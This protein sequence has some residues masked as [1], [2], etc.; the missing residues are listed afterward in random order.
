MS[1][2]RIGSNISSLQAQRKLG[3]TSAALSR[4][5]ERLAS[6]QRINRA[7]DDAAGLAI[8]E[9]LKKDVR[10][11]SQAVRNVNDGLSAL[12]IAEGALDQ[13]SAITMRQQELAAQAANGTYSLSQRRAMNTEANA[14]VEE[15]NRIVEST[16]FNG[17]QLID[18]SLSEVRIQ[19]G[20][21]AD[22]SISFGLGDELERTVG[23]GQYT[24]QGSYSAGTSSA[25]EVKAA[26][27]NGDGKPDLISNNQ[28]PAVV[29]VWNGN[30][31]GTFASGRT[32]ST[33]AQKAGLWFGWAKWQNSCTTTYS[34][35][36]GGIT[37][38]R[39]ANASVPVRR[40]QEPQRVC[41]SRTA[42]LGICP[43]GH[44]AA[45]CG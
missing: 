20:Y 2:I 15:F 44:T 29:V 18:N 8:A 22:G 32:F 11:Y 33:A 34:C 31:D 26:D 24:G 45:N 30:G 7:S 6:G 3:Q 28:S 39:C 23:T 21:G 1:A 40:L 9:S 41:M 12:Y 10:V 5:F 43:P 42:I 35:A 14:L 19:C 16:S 27:L 25:E 38:S 13:L 4:T 36:A 37:Q 17:M